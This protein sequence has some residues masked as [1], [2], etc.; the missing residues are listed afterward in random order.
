[1][2]ASLASPLKLA[3]D[4]SLA[5]EDKT[6]RTQTSLRAERDELLQCLMQ[7]NLRLQEYDQDRTNFL[8]RAMHD[9]R[10]PLTALNGYC[11]LMLGEPWGPLN[12]NQKQ[13]LERMQYSAKRLARM[14]NA[15]FDMSVDRKAQR[16][17]NLQRASIRESIEQAVQELGTLGNN[18]N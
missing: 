5:A 7:A 1:C 12:S 3:F 8:A 2:R 9:F 16:P 15:L 4:A 11:A 18:K 17:P 10:A 14:V 6:L 13:V